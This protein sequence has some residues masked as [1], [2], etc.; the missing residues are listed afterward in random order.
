[1]TVVQGSLL[2]SVLSNLLLAWISE[3]VWGESVDGCGGIHVWK[4][5]CLLLVFG[6]A[7]KKLVRMALEMKF[8]PDK[9]RFFMI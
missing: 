1:M 8:P 6:H 4:V 7:P 2:G 3:E 5:W 9:Q